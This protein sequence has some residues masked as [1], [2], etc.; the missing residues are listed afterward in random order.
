MDSLVKIANVI[1]DA[2]SPSSPQILQVLLTTWLR[3]QLFGSDGGAPAPKIQASTNT[4]EEKC[5]HIIGR[6][7]TTGV[8][9]VFFWL[10][11]GAQAPKSSSMGRNKITLFEEI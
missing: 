10:D 9:V 4:Y 1:I 6:N 11:E 7:T 8:G 3:V 2:V 5:N